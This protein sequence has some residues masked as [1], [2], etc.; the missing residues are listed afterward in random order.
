MEHHF[1]RNLKA[2]RIRRDLSQQQMADAIGVK[3]STYSSWENGYSEPALQH[4]LRIQH[5]H[6]VG[7]DVLLGASLYAYRPEELDRLCIT[8]APRPRVSRELQHA[9]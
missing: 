7:V 5:F 2:L 4:L 1:T 8:M 9:A 3:R 6:Q